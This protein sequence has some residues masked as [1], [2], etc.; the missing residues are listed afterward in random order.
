MSVFRT[1]VPPP[2]PT[3][4]DA[5]PAGAWAQAWARPDFRAWALALVLGLGLLIGLVLPPFFAWIGRST[6]RMDSASQRILTS[7]EGILKCINTMV[8]SALPFTLVL[9]LRILIMLV[10]LA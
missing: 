5:S 9:V 1:L 7:S 10:R 8:H 6:R 2:V 4:A 3:L